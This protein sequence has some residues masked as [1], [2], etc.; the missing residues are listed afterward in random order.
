M[1]KAYGSKLFVASSKFIVA[2][3]IM[4]GVLAS[5][6]AS[7]ACLFCKGGALSIDKPFNKGGTL[8]IDKPFDKGGTLSIDKPFDKGGTLSIDKPF[9]KGGTLSI[10]K[11]FDKGGTLSIDKPFD[12]GGTL[13]IDKPF[14]GV[15][16]IATDV[17]NAVKR[18][19]VETWKFLS[20][21]FAGVERSASE[22]LHQGM[23]AA[24]ALAQKIAVWLGIGLAA[25]LGFAIVLAM[26]LAALIFRR[27]HPEA[28][29][30]S[31]IQQR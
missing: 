21:P 13:S 27:T 18:P 7:S 10:D 6:P 16:R 9:D 5:S 28:A 24:A 19:F 14:D 26:G 23:D 8:S 2:T 22:L 1:R 4:T 30:H 15:G 31:P 25:V 12:K 3:V 11:P 29:R 20:N 17:W